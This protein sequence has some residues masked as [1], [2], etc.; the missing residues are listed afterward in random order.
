VISPALYRWLGVPYMAKA[1]KEF[2]K[3]VIKAALL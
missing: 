3:E 2:E 1:M